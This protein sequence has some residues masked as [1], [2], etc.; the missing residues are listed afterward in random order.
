M[1]YYTQMGPKDYR[2]HLGQVECL[3]APPQNHFC[4]DHFLVQKGPK[5]QML[6]RPFQNLTS[7]RFGLLLQITPKGARS[8]S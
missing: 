4:R 7:G 1:N 6:T 5:A 3:K 8:Q 2:I